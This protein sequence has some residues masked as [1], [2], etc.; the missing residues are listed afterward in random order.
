MTFEE[1]KKKARRLTPGRV[2]VYH[3]GMLANDRETDHQL[4][5]IGRFVYSVDAIGAGAIFQKKLGIG[6]YDYQLRVFKRLTI[7][8][9]GEDGTM[10]EADRLAVNHI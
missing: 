8:N 5:L 1:F 10:Q 9:D 2:L 4:D 6:K 3:T 7:R